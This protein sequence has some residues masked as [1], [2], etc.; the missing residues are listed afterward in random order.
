MTIPKRKSFGQHFL[1]EKGVINKMV[2]TISSAR[3]IVEIGPG[4]GAIT[5]IIIAKKSPKRLLLIE[6]DARLIPNL[7]QRFLRAEILHADGASVQIPYKD[8][9]FVSNL[10]YNAA[11]AIVMNIV[12]QGPKEMVIMV[13]KEQGER[14]LGRNG[15][16]LLTIATQLY[17]K[18]EK[19]STVGRGAFSPPPNVDSIL[20]KL[21]PHK[22]YSSEENEA[23]MRIAHAGF[24]AKRKL[25]RKNLSIHLGQSAQ[26]IDECLQGILGRKNARAEELSIEEWR[27]LHSCL[28][29]K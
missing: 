6:A 7:K 26:K 15:M 8:W 3:T 20:L 21:T 12:K 29:G 25:L 28:Q 14:M 27:T 10:P 22:Q 13:Q 17:A 1:H 4:D 9:S 23:V 24:A 11:A 18:V 19:I 5:E 16:S 2:D